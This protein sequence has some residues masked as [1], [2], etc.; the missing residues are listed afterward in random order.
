MELIQNNINIVERP[1]T[2]ALVFGGPLNAPDSSKQQTVGVSEKT[3]KHFENVLNY[4]T[5]QQLEESAKMVNEMGIDHG[6]GVSGKWS[7]IQLPE[8]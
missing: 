2:K 3:L 1:N 6:F 4:I 7:S 5:T 8:L